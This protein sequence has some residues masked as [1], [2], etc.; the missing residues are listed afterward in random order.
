[1]TRIV[2]ILMLLSVSQSSFGE[3]VSDKEL[4]IEYLQ[5]SRFEQAV[6]TAVDTYSLRLSGTMPEEER[7]KYKQFMQDVMGWN[8]IKERLAD[9]VVRLYTREEL[10]AAI[11]FHKSPV[12]I[13][14]ASKNEQFSKQF[15]EL[16][17]YNMHHFARKNTLQPDPAVDSDLP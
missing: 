8:A 12:G 15:A 13:S 17:S 3:Q 6:D 5:V 1:M 7:I 9:L 10:H 4:A 11:A 14:I 16:L 2:V